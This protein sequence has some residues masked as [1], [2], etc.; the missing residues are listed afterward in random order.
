MSCAVPKP[1]FKRQVMLKVFHAWVEAILSEKASAYLVE[2]EDLRVKMES[3]RQNIWQMRR[4]D[5]V[6]LCEAEMGWTRQRCDEE[7]VDQLRLHLREHR[8]AEVKEVQEQDP[9][10]CLPKGL[11]KLKKEL[12]IA[13]VTKRQLTPTATRPELIRQILNDVKKRTAVT[14][15]NQAKTEPQVKKELPLK[16]NRSKRS[17][18]ASSDGLDFDMTLADEDEP[19]WQQVNSEPESIYPLSFKPWEDLSGQSW[20]GTQSLGTVQAAETTAIEMLNSIAEAAAGG[21]TA[22]ELK[23]LMI[24]RVQHGLDSREL[25]EMVA[26]ALPEMGV[27]FAKAPPTVLG[28]AAAAIKKVSQNKPRP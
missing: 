13:E 19:Q 6:A 12:L 25:H 11:H 24:M 14:E 27:T 20:I 10:L 3:R 26:K 8:D 5:L 2:L 1:F 7:T 28:A 23:S 4:V 21:M 15:A 22:E 18:A 9:M 16:P 17:Q